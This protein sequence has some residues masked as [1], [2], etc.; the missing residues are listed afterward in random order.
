MLVVAHSQDA[1]AEVARSARRAA[2]F[3]WHRFSLDGVASAVGSRV[4][5]ARGLV[6][7]GDL[8]IEDRSHET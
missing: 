3:G 1:A 2:T 7:V 4:L 5:A 6:A 8:A